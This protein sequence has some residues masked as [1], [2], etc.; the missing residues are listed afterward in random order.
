MGAEGGNPDVGLTGRILLSNMRH[1]LR[2]PLN[3]V[4]GYSEL[5]M[6][7]AD[8]PVPKS[9]LSDLA[10]IN[11][12]GK[13]ILRHVNK[14]LD[15]PVAETDRGGTS[16]KALEG[17]LSS[18]VE[19]PLESILGL[20]EMLVRK[21]GFAGR[22]DVARDIE[23]I[24][25]QAA[26]FRDLIREIA[27]YPELEAQLA[28]GVT[29]PA[30]TSDLVKDLA[31]TM[32]PLSA[33]PPSRAGAETASILVVDDNELNRDLL[34]RHL[35]YQG[36]RAAAAESGAEALALL[37]SRT[38]DLILLDIIMPEMSGFQILERLKAAEAWRDIP[39]I[40]IS[41]LEEIDSVARSLE[42]GADDYLTK[43]FNSVLLRARIR[44]S[45][46]KKRLHDL[47]REQTRILEDT[48][49]RYVA[50]EVRDEILSGRIPL[51]GEVKDVS[52]LFAD[53]RDFTPLTESTPPKDV[54]RIL[55][56]YFAEMAPAISRHHGSLLRVVGDEVF[57]VFGAPLA[58]KDHPRHAVETALEMRQ[59]LIRVNEGLERQGYASLKHGVGIHS[60]PVVAANIGSPDRMVYDLVGDTV[61]LAS[62]IQELTKAFS[63]DIIISAATR[64]PLPDTVQVEKL[65]AASVKGIKE[66]VEIYRVL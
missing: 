7:E 14:I 21:A 53:L 12:A 64:K 44:S 31:S 54:V 38:F 25:S 55:N 41:S 40:M 32:Q 63:A 5:L 27:R 13:E 2:T 56:S 37:E 48:F 23:R 26:R 24:T 16:W 8:G 47:E 35:G 3:A 45:L 46:E 1:E 6:E 4:I 42:F 62:R 66:A 60:G 22:G 52:V 15:P 43:P 59:L 30:G 10:K 51:D 61:N 20:G 11:S 58:L 17:K 50:Q 28:G 19:A 36:Y 49:G 34:A 18:A 65:P 9:F 57:A 39:V 29:V 33:A